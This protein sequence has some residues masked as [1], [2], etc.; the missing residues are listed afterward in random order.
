[1]LLQY[2]AEGWGHCSTTLTGALTTP[3][4]RARQ[5][6]NLRPLPPEGSA[7]STE[8]RAQVTPDKDGVI[9]SESLPACS[10][11]LCIYRP[12]LRAPSCD[13]VALKPA[14]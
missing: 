5:D 14:A 4:R 12:G 1:M 8:L 6:S 13:H 10:P 2:P 7:L 9:A 11:G 3:V